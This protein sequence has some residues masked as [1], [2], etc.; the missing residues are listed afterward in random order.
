[1]L[2]ERRQSTD[3]SPSGRLQEAFSAAAFMAHP[4]GLPVIGWPSDLEALSR[5]QTEAFFQTYYGPGN[6]VLA[7]VGD[8]KPKEVIALVEETFGRILARPPSPPVLTTE[9]SQAG[10][11]RV[12]VEFSAEPQLLIG[13]HTPPAGHPDDDVFDILESLLSEGR[14]SRLHKRLV[15]EKQLS[16]SISASSDYPGAKYPNLFVVGVTPRAPHT[17]A[18]VEQAVYEELDRLKREPV[19]PYELQ[20]ILN[21]VDASLVRALRSNSGMASR[22]AY[23]Q[24]ING[25]WRE[26]FKQRDRIRRAAT[27]YFTKSNRVVATLVKPEGGVKETKP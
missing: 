4:Y 23:F 22:L 1:V 6:A 25:D 15:Q 19:S 26:T 2:E 27:Q 20:K 14:T 16:L 8:I 10:E 3:N 24:A 9:P 11:R 7:I 18:E 17:T 13:Y 5:A 12:E 21:Q